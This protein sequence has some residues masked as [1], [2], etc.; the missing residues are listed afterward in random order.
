MS[1]LTCYSPNGTQLF[2]TANAPTVDYGTLEWLGGRNFYVNATRTFQQFLLD[3]SSPATPLIRLSL[4]LENYFA[5]IT[6]GNGVCFQR[7]PRKRSKYLRPVPHGGKLVY[8][9][10]YYNPGSPSYFLGKFD[11]FRKA[12]SELI[13]L[14]SVG[15]TANGLAT[16]GKNIYVGYT[17]AAAVKRIRGFTISGSSLVRSGTWTISTIPNDMTFMD[18]HLWT[19]TAGLVEEYSLN[20]DGS[21]TLVNSW[22]AS[23]TNPAGICNNGKDIFIISQS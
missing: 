4:L 1:V 9:I 20:R 7:N 3:L 21:L 18:N 22:S 2:A 19:L 16:D 23:G 15:A 8:T 6:A 17:T 10:Y 13:S 12:Y 11:P 5:G 14:A